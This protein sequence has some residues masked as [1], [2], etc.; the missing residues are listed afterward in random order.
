MATVTLQWIYDNW[1]IKSLERVK[2]K[3]SR[4][5]ILLDYSDNSK[6][7]NKKGIINL[8]NLVWIIDK[9]FK[10]DY[11]EALLNKYN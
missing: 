10:K 8:N 7:K 4:I 6:L 11:N 2:N 9:D 3:P 5:Y 1:I